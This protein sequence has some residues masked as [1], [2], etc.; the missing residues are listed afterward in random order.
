MEDYYHSPNLRLRSYESGY[1]I[2]KRTKDNLG[3][4]H[5]AGQLWYSSVLAALAGL[6]DYLVRKSQ[7]PL[8][9]ALLNAADA[10]NRARMAVNQNMG[11]DGGKDA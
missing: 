4:Y 10:L 8:P 2:E 7:Q 6:S 3:D 1:V 5:W 11:S 9:D